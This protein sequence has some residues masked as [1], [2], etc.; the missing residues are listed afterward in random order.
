VPEALV[1][2]DQHA[3]LRE[4]FVASGWWNPGHDM[5]VE[6]EQTFDSLSL[7]RGSVF[8]KLDGQYLPERACVQTV[9]RRGIIADARELAAV[10]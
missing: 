3:E 5:A 9:P 7:V 4:H 6:G 1:P 10:P 8:E 2:L